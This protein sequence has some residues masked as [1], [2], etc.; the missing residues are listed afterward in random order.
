MHFPSTGNYYPLERPHSTTGELAPF[1][2]E[3]YV[4][5]WNYTLASRGQGGS[6]IVDRFLTFTDRGLGGLRSVL[7]GRA[8]P[9]S[10]SNLNLTDF[11][12]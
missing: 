5:V 3:E 1:E 9:G 10:P 6:V 12:C 4:R 11:I 7:E 2:E 8:P